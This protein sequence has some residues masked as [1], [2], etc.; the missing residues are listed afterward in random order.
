[1]RAPSAVQIILF[2]VLDDL[3]VDVAI[4]WCRESIGRAR[5]MTLE[6]FGP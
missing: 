4:Q 3:S 2:E 1:M 5:V 6:R